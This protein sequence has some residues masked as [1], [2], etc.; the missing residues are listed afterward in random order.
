MKGRANKEQLPVGK[1]SLTKRDHTN[2]TTSLTLAT[3]ACLSHT[4]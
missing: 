4:D 3:N 2:G 1:K